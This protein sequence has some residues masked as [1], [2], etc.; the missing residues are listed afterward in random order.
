MLELIPVLHQ[1]QVELAKAELSRAS[2]FSIT[3]DGTCRLGEA[4]CMVARFVNDAYEIR[5][6]LIKFVSIT[7]FMTG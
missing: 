3:F 1:Q 2:C 6:L 5:Q 7:K 4:F